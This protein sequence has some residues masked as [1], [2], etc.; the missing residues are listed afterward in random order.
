MARRRFVIAAA[1]SSGPPLRG[2]R[3][4]A[5]V[6]ERDGKLV[7]LRLRLAA[8]LLGCIVYGSVGKVF[9]FSDVQEIW[10]VRLYGNGWPRK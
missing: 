6:L 8:S 3:G 2:R 9:V 5:L 7:S 4:R 10:L 1:G